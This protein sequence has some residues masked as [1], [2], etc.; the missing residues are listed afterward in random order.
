MNGKLIS[1]QYAVVLLLA[2]ALVLGPRLTA[3]L[4]ADA[5]AGRTGERLELKSVLV[6]GKTTL[7]DFYSPGCAP[8]LALAPLMERLAAQRT[9]LAICKL[10][11]NRAGK[12]GIDWQSPLSKQYRL[13]SVPYFMIYG[14][15]GQL[16]AEG[17]PAA[18]QL[19]RWL[20]EA[21]I[22]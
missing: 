22:L 20:R 12:G 4:A 2:L 19:E 3:A 1:R 7:V 17:K 9:D 13:S 14:P 10:N 5:N 6:P 21:G 15:N 11:I 8:C 18:A 16:Q